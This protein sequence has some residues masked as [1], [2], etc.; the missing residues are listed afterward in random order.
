VIATRVVRLFLPALILAGCGFDRERPSPIEPD[1]AA[2][3]SVEVL[4]PRSGAVVGAG[5]SVTIEISARDLAGDRLE[6]VG[7]F[8]RRSGS[9]GNATLDS[10]ALSTG[11]GSLAVREFTF[12]VPANLPE[13]TQ[14]DVFG[15]AFGPGTQSRVSVP[16]SVSVSP[17]RTGVPGC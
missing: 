6:G 13:N 10:V 9:G 12:E 15:V 11:G 7:Y 16:R 17:C 1:V 8:A 3:L 4:A 14:V 5:T 2:S